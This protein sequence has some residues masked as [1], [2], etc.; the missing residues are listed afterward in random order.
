MNDCDPSHHSITYSWWQESG[1]YKMQLCAR[2]RKVPKGFDSLSAPPHSSIPNKDAPEA[3][4]PLTREE[5]VCHKAAR[6]R[7]RVVGRKAGQRLADRGARHA[8]TLQLLLAQQARDLQG[9]HTPHQDWSYWRLTPEVTA[10][11]AGTP[12]L[13]EVVPTLCDAPQPGPKCTSVGDPS[14]LDEPPCGHVAA[15]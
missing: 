13:P 10:L 12:G 3:A 9:A 11:T 5:A 7:A 6:A 8:P 15:V 2:L 4:H 1:S 14:P